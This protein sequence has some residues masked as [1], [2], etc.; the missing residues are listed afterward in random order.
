MVDGTDGDAGGLAPLQRLSSSRPEE[1]AQGHPGVEGEL[2]ALRPLNV[3]RLLDRSVEIFA[4]AF[5]PLLLVAFGVRLPIQ[6]LQIG[7][8][9]GSDEVA[10]MV[11]LAL[12]EVTMP[13][14]VAAAGARLSYAR[15]QGRRLELGAW[16]RD[17]LAAIPRLLGA[18]LLSLLV[19]G[20]MLLLFA[21]VALFGGPVLGTLFVLA[22]VPV[23][24]FLYWRLFLV[25]MVVVLERAMPLSAL[26][27]SWTLTGT[28][29]WR[30]LGVM[31]VAGLLSLPLSSSGAELAGGSA[32]E[33]LVDWIPALAGI[34]LVVLK[35]ILSAA[36]LAAPAAFL[37]VVSTLLYVDQRIRREGFDL[38]MRLER[39][40]AQGGAA[41]AGE[42]LADPT[43]PL[44]GGL[45]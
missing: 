17:V 22:A 11:V 26:G 40:G 30:W 6:V 44:P 20:P 12:L 16:T 18:V 39:L 31:V 1:P 23:F 28:G 35:C 8:L 14:L 41:R 29:F 4:S 15:L 5:L 13:L 37:S 34:G 2:P 24:F 7:F 36:L 10:D 27:R 19:F 21:L 33:L 43:A 42:A 38:H 9:A 3:G 32:D 25:Q 45:A